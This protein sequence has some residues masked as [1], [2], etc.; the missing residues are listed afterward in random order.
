[1]SAIPGYDAWKLAS[2]DDESEDRGLCP[3][4]GASSPR[5]CE[6]VAETDHNCPWE[7]SEPDPDELRDLRDEAR[8]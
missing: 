8:P 4:C 2:P 5:N 7:L 6:L 1:M 3:W